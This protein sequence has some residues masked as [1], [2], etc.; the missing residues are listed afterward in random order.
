MLPY[1]WSRYAQFSISIANQLRKYSL[2]R[3]I[4]H[5]FSGGSSNC[6]FEKFMPLSSLLSPNGGWLVKDT[7]IIHANVAIERASNDIMSVDLVNKKRSASKAFDNEAAAAA[8]PSSLQQHKIVKREPN[9]HTELT[10]EE[11]EA[12]FAIM[13]AE[14]ALTKPALSKEVKDALDRIEEAFKMG[15]A[16]FFKSERTPPIQQAFQVGS[17]FLTGEQEAKLVAMKQIFDEM[18]ERA[19]MAINEKKVLNI[20][21][22]IQHALT[23]KLNGSLSRFKDAESAIEKEERQ[24]QEFKAQIRSLRDQIGKAEEKK[25]K[26]LEE[27]Q[28]SLSFSNELQGK[29]EELEKRRPENEAKA[30][31]VEDEMKMIA[32][33]WSRMKELIASLK[34][35]FN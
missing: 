20:L 13:E 10:D 7:C 29:L 2:V 4:G 15:P 34:K 21:V 19:A 26:L 27:Q 31:A 12:F 25:K 9:Q 30:K 11:M 28:V 35:D 33:E 6:G 24:I 5:E 18:P 32:A 3:E 8:P 17:T 16:L 14:V 1:G 23:N 22:P